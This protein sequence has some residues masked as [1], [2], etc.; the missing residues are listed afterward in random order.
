MQFLHDCMAQFLNTITPHT[1]NRWGS[2][3]LVLERVGRMLALENAA[4]PQ[5]EM[6]LR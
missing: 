5:K 6:L 3:A 1:L 4:V 2:S